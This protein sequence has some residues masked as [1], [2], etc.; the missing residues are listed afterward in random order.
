MSAATFI[1]LSCDSFEISPHSIFMVHNYSGG[2]IGKGGEMKAQ[3]DHE[4]VWSRKLCE[5]VYENFLSKEEID[6]I[7]KSQD[8]WLNG[9]EVADRLRKRSE[10]K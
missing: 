6:N 1:F 9:E 4:T 8:I 2:A 3:L 5:D 7:L 10:K